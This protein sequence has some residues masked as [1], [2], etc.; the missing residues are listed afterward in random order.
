MRVGVWFTILGII[1]MCGG[2]Y[3]WEWMVEHNV[4]TFTDV[5]W[6]GA[7]TMLFGCLMITIETVGDNIIEALKKGD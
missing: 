3:E 6:L 4:F 1:C 2:N 5:V 7:V